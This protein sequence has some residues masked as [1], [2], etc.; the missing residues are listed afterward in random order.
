MGAGPIRVVVVDD[1]VFYREGLKSFLSADEGILVVG[2]ADDGPTAL[3]V[4]STA[5]PDVMLLDLNI[6]G[7]A[8]PEICARA[9][10]EHPGLRV[11]MLTTSDAREDLF[12]AVRAGAV[13]YLLKEGPP[14][15][16]GEA[17]RRVAA[18]DSLIHPRIAGS[19]LAEFAALSRPAPVDPWSVLT[20]REIEV[21]TLVAAGLRNK[22]IGERLYISEFTVKNHVRSILEK[23]ELSSRVEAAA[24]A[25]RTGLVPIA[26]AEDA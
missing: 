19:L 9:I 16:L 2:E 23:L 7:M 24:W 6:S 3:D 1:H 18:G 5:S 11:I 10:A 15:E 14:D 22:E 8:G 4:L 26:H 20:E 13:G 25:M 17:V 12:A 21:L